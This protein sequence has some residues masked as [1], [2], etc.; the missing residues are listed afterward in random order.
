MVEVY[1]RI[2][3]HQDHLHRLE[4]RKIFEKILKKFFFDLPKS[5]SSG[6]G[7]LMKSSLSVISSARA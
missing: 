7:T 6:I 1:E 5:S 2:Q 4:N 3:V